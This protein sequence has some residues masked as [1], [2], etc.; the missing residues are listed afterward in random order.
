VPG[1][2]DGGLDGQAWR[3]PPR[4]KADLQELND[5]PAGL[6]LRRVLAIRPKPQEQMVGAQGLGQTLGVGGRL[7]GQGQ[8]LA[9]GERRRVGPPEGLIMP[10]QH[11]RGEVMEVKHPP[12]AA[13]IH[14][15]GV[16]GLDD[17]CEFTG[18]EGMRECQADNLLLDV[19]GDLGCDG[20]LPASVLEGAPIQQ[21]VEAIA[22]E[23]LQI[24]PQTL[25]RQSSEVALLSEGPLAL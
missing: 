17:P 15:D 22:P 10:L 11:A 24:P 19:D 16:T 8:L 23:P 21:T 5:P 25:I 20:R 7:K 12:D 14:G 6:L 1:V 3:H 4:A 18:G 2:D 13:M 9:S